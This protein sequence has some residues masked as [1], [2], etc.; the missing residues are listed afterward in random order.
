M[1]CN[2][3]LNDYGNIR[4]SCTIYR[5]LLV[6]FLTI[7]LSISSVFVYFHWYLK[8]SV[9]NITNINTYTDTIIY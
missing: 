6:M 7:S 9:T 4:N 3:I 8:R 2:E 1:I 5:A